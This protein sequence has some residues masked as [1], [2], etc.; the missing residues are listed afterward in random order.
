MTFDELCEEYLKIDTFM[1]PQV[2]QRAAWWEVDSNEGIL[3]IMADGAL[4]REMIPAKWWTIE[5]TWG[6]GARLSAPG[7]MDCTDW[8][9][10]D[11]EQEAID[12]LEETY[13]DGMGD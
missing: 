6:F 1:E 4:E 10:F 9:V 2:T 11:T 8:C 5:F 7:Y 12:Y 3:S 13:L